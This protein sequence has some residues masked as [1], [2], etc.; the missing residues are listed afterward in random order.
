MTSQRR[1]L[2]W[3]P[4]FRPRRAI[5]SA[6]AVIRSRFCRLS[7]QRLTNWDDNYVTDNPLIRRTRRVRASS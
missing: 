6:L 3:A 4:F 1:R 2:F 5:P 7:S